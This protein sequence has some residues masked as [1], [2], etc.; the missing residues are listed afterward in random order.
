MCS[1]NLPSYGVSDQHAI[2]R[3]VCAS[4]SLVNSS[5]ELRS[6]M[7]VISTPQPW[8]GEVTFWRFIYALPSSRANF[9]R[10]LVVCGFVAV[11]VNCLFPHHHCLFTTVGWSIEMSFYWPNQ[12]LSLTLIGLSTHSPIYVLISINTTVQRTLNA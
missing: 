2:W 12:P 4:I 9:R 1:R 6:R 7:F 8:Y 11:L 10:T 3:S 5:W